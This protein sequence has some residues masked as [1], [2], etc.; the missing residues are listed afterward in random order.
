MLAFWLRFNLD[1]PED[2][3]AMML[4][5]LRKVIPSFLKRVDRDDRGGAWSAYLEDTRTAMEE[6]AAKLFAGDDPEPR[7]AVTLVDFDPEGE[8][9]LL[10]AM[11]YPYTSLPEDQIAAR[12][13]RLS[14]DE[15]AHRRR[16]FRASAA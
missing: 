13:R 10:A 12:V 6:V 8:E 5:E 14:A 2:Y 3:A 16:C 7:P 15:R 4:D 11:L 9:K 1:I